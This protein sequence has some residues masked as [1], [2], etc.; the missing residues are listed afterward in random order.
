VNFWRLPQGEERSIQD[1][2][3]G[4]V[5]GKGFRQDRAYVFLFVKRGAVRTAEK[6]HHFTSIL[7]WRLLVERVSTETSVI[8]VLMG[9]DIGLRTTPTLVEFWKDGAWMAIFKGTP[10]D[11]RSAQLGMWCY[12][13]ENFPGLSIIR[14][15]EG[16]A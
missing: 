7:T 6:A 12:L 3:R 2:V 16:H 5:E 9:E 10:L 1:Q 13:A 14:N 8:S 15:A 11:D 4:W